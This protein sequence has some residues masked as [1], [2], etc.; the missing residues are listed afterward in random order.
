MTATIDAARTGAVRSAGRTSGRSTTCSV[1][2]RRRRRRR[3][4]PLEHR[5]DQRPDPGEGH[6]D[7]PVAAHRA[8]PAVAHAAALL[9]AAAR[10]AGRH[11]RGG[12]AERCVHPL[13]RAG[14]KFSPE[15]DGSVPSRT[16]PPSGTHECA[17]DSAGTCTSTNS[18]TTRSTGTP[19]GALAPDLLPAELRSCRRLQSLRPGRGRRGPRVAACVL[20]QLTASGVLAEGDAGR[21]SRGSRAPV[22]PGDAVLRMHAT[23]ICRWA[24]VLGPRLHNRTATPADAPPDPRRSEAAGPPSSPD[25]WSIPPLYVRAR[26]SGTLGRHGPSVRQLLSTARARPRRLVRAGRGGSARR[27]AWPPTHRGCPRRPCRTRP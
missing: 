9:P 2:R 13:L 7:P 5:P 1:T 25:L 8:R 14:R 10:R 20:G 23:T 4:H 12:A 11:A 15:P 16:R 17:P 6:Q 27:K 26:Q 18:A 19:P 21:Y 24:A 22:P 3:R